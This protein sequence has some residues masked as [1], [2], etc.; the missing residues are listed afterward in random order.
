MKITIERLKVEVE[1][2]STDAKEKVDKL[3]RLNEA[4][5]LKTQES[6]YKQETVDKEIENSKSVKEQLG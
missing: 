3:R 4:L 1:A 5:N 6:I 2:H